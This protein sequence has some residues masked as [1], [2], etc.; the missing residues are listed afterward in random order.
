M[1][2]QLISNSLAAI[3]FEAYHSLDKQNKNQLIINAGLSSTL[4]LINK[5]RIYA[6]LC[7][8]G[9]VF[10]GLG[11][12]CGMRT[13]D[14]AIHSVNIDPLTLEPKLSIIGGGE[15]Q[16]PAGVCGAGAVSA[17]AQMAEAGII[18]PD[19][20]FSKQAVSPRIRGSES[21]DLEYVLYFGL[22]ASH[23]DVTISQKD[24]LSV[25]KTKSSIYAGAK[26]LMNYAGITKID[27][28]ILTGAF[29][30]YLN[31]KHALALGLFPDCHLDNVKTAAA[32]HFNMDAQSLNDEPR[33][34]IE[35]AVK[36]IETVEP[37][38]NKDYSVML[39]QAA[40]IPHEKDSFSINHPYLWNCSADSGVPAVSSGMRVDAKI[41]PGG[42]LR[43]SSSA[44][45]A[46][47]RYISLP[48]IKRSEAAAAGR[49]A[50]QDINSFLRGGYIYESLDEVKINRSLLEHPL[51]K[52]TLHYIEE[53]A[54]LPIILEISGPFSVLAALINP[55]RLYVDSL[56]NKE[57][58]MFILNNIA[59]SLAEYTIE[60]LKKGL[61]IISF[62]NVE[63]VSELVGPA[64]YAEISGAA[65]YLYLTKIADHLDQGLVHICGKS[66]YSL[67]NAGLVTAKTYRVSAEVEYIDCLFAYSQ[68]KAFRFVG[69]GCLHTKKT[70][71]LPLI[72]QLQL[73]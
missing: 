9:G 33:N 43:N 20:N 47:K 21:G 16:K 8:D 54:D 42:A 11:I 1:K 45:F 5:G 37:A 32:D 35:W 53:N 34:M 17:V 49:I 61:K 7:S 59:E 31:K 46:P 52:K 38:Y 2:N 36:N 72:Y 68:K 65:D 57:K 63:G 22:D 48:L 23:I 15:G 41:L 30:E 73:T 4:Y 28:I 51:I 67:H 12:K 13:V 60:A 14:Q 3:I 44:E 69:H 25:Q 39:A 26:Y 55:V 29:S 70:T 62:A 50:E 40:I 10:E 24:V 27:T 56:Q 71:F 18:E 19:G 66:S 6:L 64:F 58:I